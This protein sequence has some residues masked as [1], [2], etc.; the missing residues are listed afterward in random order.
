M[1][2]EPY[3][4][5]SSAVLSE[6]SFIFWCFFS[7]FLISWPVHAS[8][9]SL[10]LLS[11][12]TPQC[13]SVL[14]KFSSF[15]KDFFVFVQLLSHVWLFVTP[16]MASYQTSLSFI[17]SQSLL[18]LM[19][20]AQIHA[21]QP[22]EPLSSPTS[23]PSPTFNLSQHQGLFQWVSS[24]HQVAKSIGA[25]AS[26]IPMTIQGWFPLGLTGLISLLS[27]GLSRVFS[28]TIVQRHQ[29][30]VLNIFYSPAL[31]SIHD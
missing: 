22:S 4:D 12:S 9:Q 28:S 23:F 19:S 30:S 2:E 29:F 31:T 18:K 7:A 20:I 25:S 1:L 14:L 8:L 3:Q 13:I 5:V 26:V 27:M 10:P 6:S 17:I 16:W 21:I 15:Y 24:L 11:H